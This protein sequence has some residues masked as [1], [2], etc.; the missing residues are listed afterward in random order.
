MASETVSKIPT[1]TIESSTPLGLISERDLAAALHLCVRSLS[2]HHD[3]KTGPKRIV[4]GRR[5]FYRIATVNEWLARRE[6]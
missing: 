5:H 2:R 1:T 6:R 3:K 4:I